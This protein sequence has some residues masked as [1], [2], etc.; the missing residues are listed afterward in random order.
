MRKNILMSLLI[1]VVL[2][3][4]CIEEEGSTT[5]TETTTATTT[6]TLTTTTTKTVTTTGYNNTTTSMTE[7]ATT[8]TTTME[9]SDALKAYLQ[10]KGWSSEYNLFKPMLRDNQLSDIEKQLIEYF[11]TIPEDYQKNSK[12][13]ELLESIISDGKVTENEWNTFQD[14]DNDGISNLFEIYYFTLAD[15]LIRN[16]RYVIIFTTNRPGNIIEP[17]WQEHSYT[18]GAWE[19]AEKFDGKWTYTTKK[20]NEGLYDF[21]VNDEK[22]PSENFYLY[23]GKNATVDNLERALK[24]IS[25][26]SDEN[27]FVYLFLSAHGNEKGRI[28]PFKEVDSGLKLIPIEYSTI[29][30]WL[31]NIN[32]KYQVVVVDACGSGSAIDALKDEHRIILTS[33]NYEKAH[34]MPYVHLLVGMALSKWY[35]ENYISIRKLYEDAKGLNECMCEP[36]RDY[37]KEESNPQIYDPEGLASKIYLGDFRKSNNSTCYSDFPMLFFVDAKDLTKE[38]HFTS[39]VVSVDGLSVSS[40]SSFTTTLVYS[41]SI[42]IQNNRSEEIQVRK[43]SL[44]FDWMPNDQMSSHEFEPP[45]TLK[46]GDKAS[47][48]RFPTIPIPE[49]VYGLHRY[50]IYIET[51]DPANGVKVWEFGPYNINI[52]RT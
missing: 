51:W 25:E 23:V 14:W 2:V 18:D 20:F 17:W 46:S 21:F 40:S 35:P 16:D 29:D 3:S 50:Y 1:V 42:W 24:D 11:N 39:A 22:I 47:L 32:S 37:F 52:T 6:E 9:K 33:V 48:G 34:T 4:A 7:T 44:H 8:T 27:D 13:L 49:S 36:M 26:K 15:P 41:V 45:I 28:Y 5:I 38:I 31:D 30:K 12:V 19:C 43:V 10:S